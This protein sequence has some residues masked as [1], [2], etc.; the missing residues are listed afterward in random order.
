MR[1]TT[2]KSGQ[3]PYGPEGPEW[4]PLPKKSLPPRHPRKKTGR[5]L[6]RPPRGR[7][8]HFSAICTVSLRARRIVHTVFALVPCAISLKNALGIE[9]SPV[10]QAG[11]KDSPVFHGQWWWG[12]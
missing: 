8:E 3:N 6:P 7:L 9:E 4:G 11:K 10:P 5:F 1:E 12:R 2:K